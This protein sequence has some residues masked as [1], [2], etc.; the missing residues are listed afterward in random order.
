MIKMSINTKQ[1]IEKYIKIR[2]KNG[3]LVNLV[4]NKPQQKLY[5]II[6]ELKIA[7][8]PVRIVILKARQMGFSTIVGAIL[9]KETT[10]KFNV[11]TGIITHQEDATKNLFNMSKLMYECLPQ[12]MKPSK[13]ASNAQELIFDNER[14]TGLKSKIRCM[15][16]GSKGVGRSYTYNNLHASEFAFWPGDKNATLVG[17]LQT[18]PYSPDTAVFIESTANGFDEFK[19]IWDGAVNGDNDFVPLFVGWNELEEYKMP[20]TG[21]EL[22][23][24]EN[25]LRTEYNLSL[26]QI[27]WRR[28]CIRN[29]CGNDIEL[30]KQ[31]Y[32]ICPEE[33]FISTGSCYF[34]KEIIMGR[35]NKIRNI[36]P[37]KKGYFSYTLSNNEIS[38]IEFIEDEKGYIDIFEDA[39]DGHPYV[40]GGDTAGEGSDYFTG[41]VIDNSNSRQVAKLRHNKIDEDEYARQ[42]YCLGMY[43]N[44]AL[45]GLEN[46]YSTYPTKKLKEYNYP[47]L[48]I[49]EVEDNIAEIIQDKFGFVTSKATRPIILAGLKEIFR[50]NIECIND[51]DTLNE[52]LV[53]IRNEKG[54]AEAS[55]GEHD[56]LIMGLAITYYIREQQDFI[57]K[58]VVKE[59]KIELPFALQSDY[60]ETDDIIGW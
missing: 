13:K 60:V 9:F 21:F 7:G 24:E 57:V 51:I 25:Q 29:N 53:F 31:E 2:N 46:N 16:A 43:Y 26:E 38:D 8:K 40:L 39:L 45:I 28:W 58:Q 11:N 4:L 37:L 10:T 44:T 32:P 1:Y 12:E 54:R 52:A 33:A 35:I 55:P 49:R 23:S 56:D 59:K 48:F 18:V 42:I 47:K 50:D 27:T 20:Y 17:L 3:N 15:T 19:E 14:G 34:N 22:T 5:N 6:K 30:F 36:K 41:H